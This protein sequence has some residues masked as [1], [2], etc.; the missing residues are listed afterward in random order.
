MKTSRDILLK[1]GLLPKLQLGIKTPKGVQSTGKHTVKVLD[2][3]IIRK[4]IREEGD[5]GY[6]VRYTFE[7]NGEKK[8]YDTRMKQKGGTDPSYFVQSMADIEIGEEI[9]LEMKKSGVKNY[10]EILRVSNGQID[11]ADVEDDEDDKP[12]P[13]HT[14]STAPNFSQDRVPEELEADNRVLKEAEDKAKAQ[15][16]KLIEDKKAELE[17]DNFNK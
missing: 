16:D 6:F 15:V 4:T 1:A 11:T 2:D 3:K 10:V 17:Y 5:D 14:P 8:Q 12:Q 9:S 7:E 13:P